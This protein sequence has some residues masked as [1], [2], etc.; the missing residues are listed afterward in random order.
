MGKSELAR[1]YTTIRI[2]G[3]PLI[4]HLGKMLGIVALLL[5][6]IAGA[7]VARNHPRKS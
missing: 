7:N 5:L 2:F 6:A 4:R 3:V 1:R